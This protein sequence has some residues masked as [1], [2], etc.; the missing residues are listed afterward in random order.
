M[1]IPMRATKD[2]I[3]ISLDCKSNTRQVSIMQTNGLYSTVIQLIQMSV[4]K[5][6]GGYQNHRS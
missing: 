2:M 4:Q 6:K 1:I 5:H 3:Y